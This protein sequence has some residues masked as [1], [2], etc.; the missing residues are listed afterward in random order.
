[1]YRRS[2]AALKPARPIKASSGVR[3]SFQQP[4]RKALHR[5]QVTVASPQT[6]AIVSQI[7]DCPHITAAPVKSPIRSALHDSDMMASTCCR[8]SH[9]FF[10]V[11]L[12]GEE[13]PKIRQVFIDRPPGL[14][15]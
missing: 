15:A 12:V 14:L 11:A 1:M 8:S 10:R 13:C 4:L 6:L 7:T 3:F 9:V 5:C 2:V